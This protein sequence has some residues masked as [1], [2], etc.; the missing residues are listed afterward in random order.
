MDGEREVQ[1]PGRRKRRIKFVAILLVR[2]KKRG[3]LKVSR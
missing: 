3:K 1:E 2:S